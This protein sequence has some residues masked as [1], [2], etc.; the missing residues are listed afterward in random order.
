MTIP[1]SDALDIQID[2]RA[3]LGGVRDQGARNS[4]L[5][6]AAS[7]AH[8][9]R[10]ALTHPLSAEFLYYHAGL[11]MPGGNGTLGLSFSAVDRALKLEGQ[12]SELECPYQAT[13]PNPWVPP[14]ISQLW[15]GKL[16]DG[17]GQSSEIVQSLRQGQPVV[18]AI[19]LTGDFLGVTSP[20]YIVHP[21]GPAFGAHAVLAVGLGVHRT[22]GNLVLMRNS[23]GPGWGDSG[24]A[25]LA[26][27]YLA[28]NMIGFRIVAAR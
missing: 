26:P 21:G 13:D 28:N 2:L 12:P 9:R 19:Q 24:H 22:F 6:C 3:S 16:S 1:G 10:H 27:D 15:H 5:S 14:N 20:P 8:M 17:S 23:W 4:C 25:W 7:D 11:L 18:I